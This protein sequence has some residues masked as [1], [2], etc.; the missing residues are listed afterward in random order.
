M[1]TKEYFIFI[2]V[3]NITLPKEV[4]I[5]ESHSSFPPFPFD[6][7]GDPQSST[8]PDH[9]SRSH[10]AYLFKLARNLVQLEGHLPMEYKH[11]STP[12]SWMQNF[13]P[14]VEKFPEVVMWT[15]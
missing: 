4:Y 7:L 12:S 13:N 10:T 9:L 6:P 8:N 3:K 11:L 15:L 1:Q 14:G 5:N 2:P